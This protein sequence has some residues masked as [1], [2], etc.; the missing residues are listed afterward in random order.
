MKISPLAAATLAW[1]N[2]GLQWM[3]MMAASGQAFAH[4][5]GRGNTP[6]KVLE[7]GSE[8]VLASIESSSAMARRLLSFPTSNAIAMSTAWMRLLGSGM[9]PYRVRA[10]RN[11]RAARRRR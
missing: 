8:K 4:R 6:A 7:M 10:V 2:L 5:A 3:E 11:A 1:S 9:A